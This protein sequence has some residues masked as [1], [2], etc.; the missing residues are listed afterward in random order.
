MARMAGKR[1]AV[2]GQ[3]LA[4]HGGILRMANGAVLVA[5]AHHR[6]LTHHWSGQE[7]GI[8]HLRQNN[9]AAQ[10]VVRR[11]VMR[12]L[13]ALFIIILSG[14]IGVY[15]DIYRHTENKVIFWL[16]GYFGGLI[17]TVIAIHSS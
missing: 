4:G 16:I 8:A 1:I 5:H 14:S 12:I 7:K 6:K 2:I 9:P 10:L 3:K 11:N 17:S 15:L 13:M